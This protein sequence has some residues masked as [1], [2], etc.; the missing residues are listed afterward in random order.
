MAKQFIESGD[1]LWNAGIF[2][3]S[4]ATIQK[5]FE[6]YLPEVDNL[7]KQGKGVYNTPSEGFIIKQIYEVCK[8]ISI[9]YGIMEKA[10]NVYVYAGNFSWSDLGTWGS[11]FEIRNK[12]KNNNSVIGKRVKLY[13]S[14]NCIVNMPKNK[15]VVVQGLDDYIVVESEDILL[16][17]KK[18]DEQQIRQFVTDVQVDF[19]DKF[20]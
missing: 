6:L 16:I 3:W 14:N 5:A 13:N 8:N 11:L 10:R 12:D 17:C 7:F 4:L 1:F 2:M 18:E 19:G 15:V 20:V 9:D